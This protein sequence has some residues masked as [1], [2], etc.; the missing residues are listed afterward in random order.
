MMARR[1]SKRFDCWMHD[2]KHRRASSLAHC[3]YILSLQQVHVFSC[4]FWSMLSSQ[5]NVHVSNELLL[6]TTCFSPAELDQGCFIM[7]YGHGLVLAQSRAM[8]WTYS[9]VDENWIVVGISTIHTWIAYICF[10][11]WRQ[12]LWLAM[13]NNLSQTRIKVASEEYS[14][15][16]ILDILFSGS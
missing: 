5:K 4:P 2:G 9:I 1:K 14:Y 11:C 6:T 3:S 16:Q 7:W 12:C 13:G 8:A 15:S 10:L